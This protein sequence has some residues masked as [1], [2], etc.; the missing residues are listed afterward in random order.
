MKKYNI[1]NKLKILMI[2]LFTVFSG[3]I[4]QACSDDDSEGGTPVVNYI[5]ITNPASADSLLVGSFLGNT[6]LIIGENLQDV[7]EI[8]FND[9]S[10]LINTSFVSYTSIIVTVPVNAPVVVTNTMRLI[11]SSHDTVSYPFVINVPAPLI[12]SL[13]CEFLRPGDNAVVIGNYFIDNDVNPLKVFFPPAEGNTPIEGIITSSTVER[14]EV[15]VPEGVG[16]GNIIVKSNFGTTTSS[17][18]INDLRNDGVNTVQILNYDN[19][20]NHNVWRAG[21]QRTDEN[22]I[23]GNYV[24]LKGVYAASST[25]TQETEDYPDGGFVSEFWADADGRP[26]GNLLPSSADLSEWDLKF[27]ANVVEWTGAYLQF[28]WGPWNASAGATNGMYWGD[29]WNARGFWRPWEGT[30]SHSFKTDGKWI[31]VT[32]PMSEMRYTRQFGDMAF[33]RENFGSLTMWVAGPANPNES[34]IEMYIDNVRL[35]KR[36]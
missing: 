15:T 22:S 4:F 30:E 23:D 3:L 25:G 34:D 29:T 14:I 16:S 33:K 20:T 18:Y 8:Y 21:V 7:R 27:E 36:N 9:Q 5:R 1:T 12:N 13:Q 26:Q 19:L 17:A 6:V 10:A 35:A 24:M 28:C 31:T 11:T 32:I 2:L